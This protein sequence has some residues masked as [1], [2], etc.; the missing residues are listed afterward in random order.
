MTIIFSNN[1][2]TDCQVIKQAWQGLKD[3]NIVKVYII[4]S[5]LWERIKSI[6]WVI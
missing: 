1:M 6:R 3:I 2:D 5:K 4:M